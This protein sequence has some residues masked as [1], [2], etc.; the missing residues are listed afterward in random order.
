[1]SCSLST[2]IHIGLQKV[3]RG[4]PLD[5]QQTRDREVFRVLKEHTSRFNHVGKR[6]RQ[7]PHSV[8]L[9]AEVDGHKGRVSAPR[10]RVAMLMFVTAL[11]VQKRQS[12][13]RILQSIV[14]T[15]IHVCM[16][17]RPVL[18]I[19]DAVFH[20]GS[21]H[22]MDAPFILSRQC[23]N[24]LSV[25]MIL[26]PLIQTD[27]RV[28]VC[29]E[30]FTMD[31]SPSGG[32]ICR[33]TIGQ[34]AAEE[35][36][37]YYT[38]LQDGAGV[39]VRELGLDRQELFGSLEF[40]GLEVC[41]ELAV[42]HV[43]YE[44]EQPATFDCVELFSGQG[45]WSRC[46]AEL[47]LRVHPG[48]E[49]AASGVKFGDI[50]DKQTFLELANLAMSGDVEEWHAGPPCWS[51]GTL[52]RPRLRSIEFPAGFN[53]A[54]VVTREQT[55]LAVR[56]AFILILAV[57]AGCFIS[58]EQPGGSVMFHLRIFRVLISLGCQVTRF[59]FCSY[60]SGFNKPSKSLHNKPW[61]LGLESRC[62]CRYKGS[63]LV[64]QGS[65]TYAVIKEFN[66]RC[67]PNTK[68]IYGKVPRN[69]EAL[70]AF[71]A[72]YPLPLCRRMA[73]GSL[74]AHRHLHALGK[75]GKCVSTK[76]QH[77]ERCGDAENDDEDPLPQRPWYQDP[78]WVK[79]VCETLR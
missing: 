8:V 23:I 67:V 7:V 45:N 35:Q 6:Q 49:R 79:D 51:F 36:R 56:T 32:A 19:F 26:G 75:A 40:T 78:G 53:I 43:S 39:V 33:S 29:P 17:R 18:S 66:K 57:Q 12:A 71:S 47:G 21:Q 44:R 42:Q 62:S 30:L 76:L 24:E 15:W 58:C 72:A 14:G 31:A 28:S 10:H 41:S 22:H 27:L 70:S 5:L 9:G 38:R 13:K 55:M 65:F 59:P 63:H 1:M 74:A 73:A 54:D 37:G 25:L 64:I 4:I 20:E 52:R 77:R 11:V 2:T 60:G 34:F 61:Y 68:D 69:G 46:H 50:S 3:Q 16:F 48:I